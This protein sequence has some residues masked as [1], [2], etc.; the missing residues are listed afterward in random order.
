MTQESKKIVIAD[1]NS[2]IHRAYHALPR[3]STKGGKLVNAVYGFL[4]VFFKVVEELKPDFFAVAFDLPAPTFRHKKYKEYKATRKKAPQELYDQIPIIKEVLKELNVAMFEKSG[5]EADDIIGTIAQ[6]TK[7]DSPG[8]SIIIATGD[9]DALQLIDETTKVYV[10]RKGVKDIVLYDE[11]TI[12]EKFSGLKP[13]Q[14]I[15]Y[16]ALRGDT[17][18]NIP[19]VKGVGDKTAI[20]LLLKFGSLENIY[21]EIKED[22]EKSADLK[23]KLR[24]ILLS[25]E[26]QAFFSKEMVILDRKSPIDFQLEE[27]KWGGYDKEKVI[28]SFNDLEF[29]T[30]AKKLAGPAE[31]QK[32]E[33]KVNQGKLL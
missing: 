31:T 10:L 18:D 6:R 16:K 20:D 11:K 28:K 4:L 29:Y 22:S 14:L 19:G 12:G 25:S 2:I 7:E 15:D 33:P 8:I 32:S 5:F 26:K 27:C 9:S 30:L 3:L 13:G 23:G 24:E 17:S 21:K 1:G